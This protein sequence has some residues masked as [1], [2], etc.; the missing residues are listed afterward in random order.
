VN[1]DGQIGVTEIRW[2]AGQDKIKE[3]DRGKTIGANWCP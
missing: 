3:K 1:E 2:K